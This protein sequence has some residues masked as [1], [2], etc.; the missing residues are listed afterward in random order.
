MD[1]IFRFSKMRLSWSWYNLKKNFKIWVATILFATV[2]ATMF[3]RDRQPANF[4][5]H[6]VLV[7]IFGTKVSE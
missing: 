5:S 7:S 3:M 1:D 2:F 6:A 4:L